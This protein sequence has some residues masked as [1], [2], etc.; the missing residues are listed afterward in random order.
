MAIA[1]FELN[2]HFVAPSLRLRPLARAH[3]A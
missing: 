1:R 2:K 3:P